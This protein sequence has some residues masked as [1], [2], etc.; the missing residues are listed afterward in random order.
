MQHPL[1]H[2]DNSSLRS[3]VLELLKSG[4]LFPKISNII[5][6]CGGNEINQLRPQFVSYCEGNRV[7]FSVFQPEYAIKYALAEDDEPFNLSAFEE[8]IGDLS[9]A[10]IIFPEAPG[11]YA[12][13]G[14][15]SGIDRL[16]K[17][18]ILVLNSDYLNNDSFLSI[19]P[20]KLFGDKTRFHPAIQFSY[21]SPDFGIIVDRIK[22]RIGDARRRGF[23]EKKFS[24]ISYFDKYI[25]ILCVFEIL[26]IASVDDVIFIMRGLFK[27]RVDTKQIKYLIS[28]MIGS[29]L[30][31]HRGYDEDYVFLK[32][33]VSGIKFRDGFG[34]KRNALKIE[35][36]QLLVGVGKLSDEVEFRAY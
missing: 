8:I 36:S 1:I 19:G 28:I 10:I 25:I 4:Y 17:K 26:H 30:I 32:E 34:E 15:F 31:G 11:S 21:K 9:F 33:E 23:Q 7:D 22:A 16:A 12:E 6:V 5:F 2:K 14:Y 35:I 24:E 18:S 3:R 13:A 27:G 20:A 29:G